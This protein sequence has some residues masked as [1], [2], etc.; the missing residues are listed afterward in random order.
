MPRFDYV[1]ALLMSDRNVAQ[2]GRELTLEDCLDI[3]IEGYEDTRARQSAIFR[4]RTV[5]IYD[6]EASVRQVLM[7]SLKDK[8]PRVRWEAYRTV[9]FL[10]NFFTDYIPTE[11]FEGPDDL[12]AEVAIASIETLAK[13]TSSLEVKQRLAQVAFDPLNTTSSGSKVSQ[14]YRNSQIRAAAIRALAQ[15]QAR[16]Y[17]SELLDA[18]ESTDKQ[19][20][21][22]AIEACGVL[23]LWQAVSLIVQAITQQDPTPSVLYTAM[24]SLGEIAKQPQERT[25]IAGMISSLDV[26]CWFNDKEVQYAAFNSYYELFMSQAD[27]R[28]FIT[29]RF[30]QRM[31]SVLV[32]E[33]PAFFLWLGIFRFTRVISIEI[34]MALVRMTF[35]KK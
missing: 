21:I 27:W 20:Q 6:K 34:V 16:E 3:L 28:K 13:F 4:L 31:R 17:D 15:I 5:A 14:I 8:S 24:R 29:L 12:E 30:T 11:F 2:I 35:K 25:T 32:W 19:I 7:I 22:A 23:K 33:F 10:S 1:E 9:G 18:I 26:G